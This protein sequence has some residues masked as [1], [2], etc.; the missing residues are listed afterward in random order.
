L[1]GLRGFQYFFDKNPLVFGL[2]RRFDEQFQQFVK[3]FLV[4]GV[5]NLYKVNFFALHFT[6][7]N[8]LPKVLNRFEEH[9]QIRKAMGKGARIVLITA[10]YREILYEAH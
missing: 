6:R 7:K 2:C 1:S 8:V 4:T 3:L 9:F 10:N 5:C